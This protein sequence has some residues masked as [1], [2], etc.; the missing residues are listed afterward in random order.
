MIDFN[1]LNDLYEMK[2][3]L[4][5]Q[6]QSTNSSWSFNLSLG[7]QVRGFKNKSK[8]YIHVTAQI[9]HCSYSKINLKKEKKRRKEKRNESWKRKNMSWRYNL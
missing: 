5:F 6:I 9:E 1:V 8:L 2:T 7:L 4:Q 3:Y